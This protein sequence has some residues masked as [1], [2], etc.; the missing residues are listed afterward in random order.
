VFVIKPLRLAAAGLALALVG[1]ACGDDGGPGTDASFTTLTDGVLLI[2][3]DI[4]YAPFEFEDADSPSGYTGF[5]IELVDAVAQELDLT[6]AV[7]VQAF[8]PIQNGQALESDT[9]DLAASAMTINAE[10]EENIDFTDPYFDADQSMLVK[11]DNPFASLDELGGQSVGVQ[12]DTTGQEY[13]EDNVGDDVTVREFPG[14]PELFQ[15]L[16][17]GDIVAIIQDLPVNAE[18][19]Q[20]DDTVE[21]SATFPTGE[22]YGFAVKQDRGDDLLSAIN[23]ALEA[24]RAD[25]TYDEIYDKYFG[26][27]G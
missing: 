9:C 3:S 24:V 10:R 23:D 17:A 20:Q 2:C 16:E 19:A 12:A 6:I 15:A 22:Q 11:S 18:R 21:V 1:V 8:D 27:D 25:G 13:A 5:D 4:P 14:A 7:T 26:T